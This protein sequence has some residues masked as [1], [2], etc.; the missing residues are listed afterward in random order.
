MRLMDRTIGALLALCFIATLCQTAPTK[1]KAPPPIALPPMPK[2]ATN[3]ANDPE[4]NVSSKELVGTPLID[5]KQRDGSGGHHENNN[6]MM[7]PLLMSMM[8]N[9]GGGGGGGRYFSLTGD[10]HIPIS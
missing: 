3:N 5:A 2:N 8:N 10:A 9:N 1:E 7:L 4:G 6:M